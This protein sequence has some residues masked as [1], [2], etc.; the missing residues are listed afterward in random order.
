MKRIFFFMIIGLSVLHAQN[1]LTDGVNNKP[2]ITFKNEGALSSVYDA[3]ITLNNDDCSATYQFTQF[4]NDGF[5]EKTN[6]H[7]LK[8]FWKDIQ[9]IR[10]DKVLNVIE[11]DTENKVQET[12][13]D[14]MSNETVKNNKEFDIAIY[15]QNIED[16]NKAVDWI[17]S[18]I[19]S[20]G[21]KAILVK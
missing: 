5:V 13:T 16:T 2:K 1:A 12:T 18:K 21:G 6:S 4:W 8:W 7:S 9:S 20:C 17:N 14:M 10:I 19:S 15:F 3:K 11:L